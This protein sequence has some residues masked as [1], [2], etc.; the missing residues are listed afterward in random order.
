MKVNLYTFSLGLLLLLANEE[1]MQ[2]KL[3][4]LFNFVLDI[5][6]KFLQEGQF[7]S[8]IACSLLEDV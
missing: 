1:K 4:L 2:T 5:P 6:S 7:P 8:R 3:K